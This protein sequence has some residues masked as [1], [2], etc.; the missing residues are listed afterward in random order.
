MGP[1]LG[2]KRSHCSIL[3]GLLTVSYSDI[4]FKIRETIMK[5]LL[6]AELCPLQIHMLKPPTS[7]KIIVGGAIIRFR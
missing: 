6:W 1:R 4:R 5:V 3:L 7:N 2:P